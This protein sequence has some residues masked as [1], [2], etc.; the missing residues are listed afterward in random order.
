MDS[1]KKIVVDPVLDEWGEPIEP[2]VP[3]ADKRNKDDRQPLTPSRQSSTASIRAT[4]Q[5]S[6]L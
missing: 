6:A 1:V 4:S 2:E 5:R 3:E